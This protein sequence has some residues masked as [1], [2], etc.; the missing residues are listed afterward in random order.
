MQ[1]LGEK[2]VP[3]FGPGYTGLKNLG[4]RW[5]YTFPSLPTLTYCSQF[6]S[7]QLLLQL[8][9]SSTFHYPRVCV[10][11]SQLSYPFSSAV[12]SLLISCHPTTHQLSSHYSSA[13]IPLLISCHPILISCHPITLQ[14]SSHYSSAVIPFLISCHPI[15]LQLSSPYHSTVISLLTSCHTPLLHHHARTPGT[16][17]QLRRSSPLPLVYLLRTLLFRCARWLLAYSQG[18]TPKLPMGTTLPHPRRRSQQ[19]RNHRC[20]SRA[21]F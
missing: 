1:E 4:N 15:T 17:T 11:V 8:S 2:L 21:V 7:Q 9:Y 20:A 10:Q 6:L 13:V 12:I 14:L 18:G 5:A 19:K 16:L 3:V